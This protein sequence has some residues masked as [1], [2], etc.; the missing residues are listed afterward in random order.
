MSVISEEDEKENNQL[1]LKLNQS[2][3]ESSKSSSSKNSEKED[4]LVVTSK[5]LIMKSDYIGKT[6]SPPINHKKENQKIYDLEDDIFAHTKT[7][8]FSSEIVQKIDKNKCSE[9][10]STEINS[11]RVR[12]YNSP[13]KR[14]SII[15]LVEKE[16]R[17]KRGIISTNKKEEKVISPIKKE[18]RDIFGN[19]INKKNKKNV[20]VSF[21]DFTTSQ[22]L[23][24]VVDIESF[25][26]YNYI[27]GMPKEK[28]IEKHD[29]CQCCITF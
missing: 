6:A 13:R 1:T 24:D 19:L 8:L 16:K 18:R 17:N 11:I 14:Y 9:M 28:I 12:N 23:V 26:K 29:K 10:K 3:K 22:P 20:K 25:K 4:E 5:C 21:V 2:L 7:N 15:K 27:I